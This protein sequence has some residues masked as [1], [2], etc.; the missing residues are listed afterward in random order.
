MKGF[1]RETD[2]LKACA[3]ILW[4]RSYVMRFIA[5]ADDTVL[6]AMTRRLPDRTERALPSAR[7]LR[8]EVTSSFRRRQCAARSL[9]ARAA[10]RDEPDDGASSAPAYTM[11]VR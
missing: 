8:R 3:S 7:S 11:P 1:P 4:V 6:S 2:V 10:G 5:F 9:P